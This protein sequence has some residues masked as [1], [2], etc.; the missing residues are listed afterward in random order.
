MATR[1]A[2][3]GFVGSQAT[4]IFNT[5][6]VNPENP[7]G[8]AIPSQARREYLGENTS[9]AVRAFALKCMGKVAEHAVAREVEPGLY[10]IEFPEAGDAPVKAPKGK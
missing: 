1:L 9:S 7:S 6:K 8:P 3:L 10:S 5:F 4:L 2:L